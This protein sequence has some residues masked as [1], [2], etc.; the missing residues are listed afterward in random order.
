MKNILIIILSLSILTGC[1]K[2]TTEE[3]KSK[4]DTIKVD[5]VK[6]DTTKKVKVIK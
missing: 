5:T 1:A 6:K 3:T 2:K 4:N